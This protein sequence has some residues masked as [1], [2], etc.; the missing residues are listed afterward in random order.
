MVVFLQAA[1]SGVSLVPQWQGVNIQLETSIQE[2]MRTFLIS[3]PNSGHNGAESGRR[4]NSIYLYTC[5]ALLFSWTITF[6]TFPGETTGITNHNLRL[7]LG[8]ESLDGISFGRFK[9]S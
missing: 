5:R 9:E 1:A 4:V 6:P 7:A 8:N 3:L 2:V